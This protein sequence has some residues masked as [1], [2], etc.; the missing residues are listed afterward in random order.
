MT[1]AQ[2]ELEIALDTIE[3]LKN[4]QRMSEVTATRKIENLDLRWAIKTMLYS[5]FTAVE[6]ELTIERIASIVEM[7]K[8]NLAVKCTSC[9]QK[10]AIIECKK[11]REFVGKKC[12]LTVQSKLNYGDDDIDILPFIGGDGDID[13]E[14]K[15]EIERVRKLKEKRGDSARI[16]ES[17]RLKWKKFEYYSFPINNCSESFRELERI[18]KLLYDIYITESGIDPDNKVMDA[19]KFLKLRSQMSITLDSKA[20]S[21][22]TLT[23][24]KRTFTIRKPSEKS[25]FKG[26]LDHAV[27]K[28]YAQFRE[29]SAFND[30]EKLFMNRI[31][32]LVFKRHGANASFLDFFRIVKGLQVSHLITEQQFL[33]EL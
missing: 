22:Q 9:T 15:K 27:Q 8:N 12:Y 21:L 2:R 10:K 4:E 33:L 17:P 26:E 19:N 32:F 7:N 11:T 28:I 18:F 24:T 1:Y 29:D 6:R 25:V 16:E 20:P 31:A 5:C 13:Q 30:E 14:I 3:K 23:S